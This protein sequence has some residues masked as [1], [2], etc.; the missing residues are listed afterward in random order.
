M[1]E[2]G[3]ESP[4]CNLIVMRGEFSMDAKTRGKNFDESRVFMSFQR[5]PYQSLITKGKNSKLEVEKRKD[6]T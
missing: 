5:F 1:I 4:C 6:P 3:G 2:W